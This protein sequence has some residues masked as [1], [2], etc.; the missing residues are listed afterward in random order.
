MA[1]WTTDMASIIVFSALLGNAHYEWK[2]AKQRTKLMV[3]LRRE[4]W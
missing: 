3:A 1:S 2:G 4:C